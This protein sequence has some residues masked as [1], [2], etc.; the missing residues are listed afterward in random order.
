MEIITPSFR[1]FR[2]GFNETAYLTVPNAVSLPELGKRLNW[3][4]STIL[5]MYMGGA[6]VLG[7]H[8]TPGQV[9]S[10]DFKGQFQNIWKLPPRIW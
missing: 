1:Q 8:N 4:Y 9:I 10:S 3:I 5:S 2:G 7:I 6:G